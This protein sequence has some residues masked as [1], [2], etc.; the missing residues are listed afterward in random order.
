MI[1]K[2]VYLKS[3]LF[4]L[5]F[6]LLQA[7]V[8]AQDTIPLNGM[9]LW[10]RADSVKLSGTQVTELYDLSG[11]NNNAMKDSYSGMD[12]TVPVVVQNAYNGHPTLRFNGNYTGFSYKQLSDIRT[13]IAVL[14][15]DSAECLLD[16][17]NYATPARFFVG[18]DSSTNFHPCHCCDIYNSNLSEVSPLLVNGMTFVNGKLIAD[19]RTTYFPFVLGMVS[20]IP[21]GAVQAQTVGRDRTFSN[22]SWF[23][24]ICEIIIYN[25]AIDTVTLRTIHN[26]LGAK[27][28]IAGFKTSVVQPSDKAGLSKTA[29]LVSMIR[30]NAFTTNLTITGTGRYSLKIFNTKGQMAFEKTGVGPERVSLDN[31]KLPSGC[32]FVSATS[33]NV[34]THFSFI[35]TTL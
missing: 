5:L 9:E 4:L 2:P 29:P 7:S 10:I 13:V 12:P 22:R 18:D 28:G 24:D 32:C 33:N 25:K 11:N 30:P 3:S 20:M 31:K 19:G 8:G 16:L 35:N 1:N 14:Q 34:E 17:P 6:L 21:T 26:I 15:K 27:Y 23:G